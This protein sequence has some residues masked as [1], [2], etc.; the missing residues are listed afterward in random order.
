[1]HLNC[2]DES[3]LATVKRDTTLVSN[4][5]AEIFRTRVRLVLGRLNM[6]CT[7]E[8]F[9]IFTARCEIYDYLDGH[10]KDKELFGSYAVL[11]VITNSV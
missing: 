2:S 1:M 8:S 4:Q 3:V 11:P 9:V 10:P 6:R 5:F 7:L